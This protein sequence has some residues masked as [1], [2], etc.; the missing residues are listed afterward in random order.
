M[1]QR[2][3]WENAARC[4]S[5]SV[6]LSHAASSGLGSTCENR[7]VK[8]RFALIPNLNTA[9]LIKV[10]LYISTPSDSLRAVFTVLASKL[11]DAA[12]FL[13]RAAAI[14]ALCFT[15]VFP[16]FGSDSQFLSR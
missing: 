5:P 7:M 9:F 4:A 11:N 8:C 6:C 12:F 2:A 1:H 13:K 15:G 3:E 16:S 14:L 10:E